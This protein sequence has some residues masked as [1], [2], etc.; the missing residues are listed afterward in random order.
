MCVQ[1]LGTIPAIFEYSVTRPVTLRYFTPIV[2]LLGVVWIAAVTFVNV[3]VVG[4]DYVPLVSTSFN[5]SKELWYEAYM[6]KSW[7]PQTRI[8]AG[9]TIKIDEGCPI[10]VLS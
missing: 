3:V 2:L 1:H 10:F 5:T 7:A 4:Y 6:P 9:S 8:C